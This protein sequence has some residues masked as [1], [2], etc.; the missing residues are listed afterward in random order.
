MTPSVIFL[1]GPSS[2][3]KTTLG[4]ALQDTLDEPYLL[5]GLD[6]CFAMVPAQ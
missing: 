3:G 2:A 6:T 4:K 1:N 5:M